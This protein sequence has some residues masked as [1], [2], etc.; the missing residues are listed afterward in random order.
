MSASSATWPQRS[1]PRN[2]G[3]SVSPAASIHSH[4]AATGHSLQASLRVVVDCANGAG[5]FVAPQSRQRHEPHHQSGAVVGRAQ[6]DV[7]GRFGG[8]VR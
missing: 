8:R 1:M 7:G 2:S 3:P 4:V 5:Y 6:G